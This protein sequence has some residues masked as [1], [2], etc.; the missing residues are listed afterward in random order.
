MGALK[1]PPVERGGNLTGNGG[2]VYGTVVS[3]VWTR[4]SRSKSKSKIRNESRIKSR[5]KVRTGSAS[6]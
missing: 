3:E 4:K 6:S 1:G 2:F 5:R